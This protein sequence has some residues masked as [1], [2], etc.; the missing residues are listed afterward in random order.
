MAIC[1]SLTRI[2]LPTPSHLVN[3]EKL[4]KNVSSSCSTYWR[5]GDEG[6]SSPPKFL[7]DSYALKKFNRFLLSSRLS[8][9]NASLQ[10][11]QVCFYS[12]ASMSKLSCVVWAGTRAGT[13]DFLLENWARRVSKSSAQFPVEDC[14]K[15]LKKSFRNALV[16]CTGVG[17]SLLPPC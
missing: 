11:E 14:R 8:V 12:V 4:V 9:T 10:L 13:S 3:I 15:E 6:I 1:R 7:A 5:N 17:L 2:F 16:N